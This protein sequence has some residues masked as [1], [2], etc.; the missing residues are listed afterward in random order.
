M[1]IPRPPM[2]IGN[3]GAA[4]DLIHS[5][6]PACLIGANHHL[7]PF[8]GEDFQ[9]F[10]RDLPGEN[11][12]GHSPDAA[13]GNLPLETCDTINNSWGYNA[14]DKNY[15]SVATLVHNLVRA[16][17][18]NANYLLN[19]GPLPDGT[20]DSGNGPPTGGH[21]RMDVAVWA[22][23][24]RHAQ[25][26]DWLP[27]LGHK[28][29]NRGRRLSA[30]PRPIDGR[31]RRLAHPFG[32]GLTCAESRAR[33][34]QWRGSC[35]TPRRP[36]AS[37]ES[38]QGG[39][40]SRSCV[41]GGEVRR[42]IDSEIEQSRDRELRLGSPGGPFQNGWIDGVCHALTSFDTHCPVPHLPDCFRPSDQ[43]AGCG[44]RTH[45]RSPTCMA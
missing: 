6:Q 45:W 8:E 10:E 15:K 35:I 13:V 44:I 27:A 26:S 39:Q 12:S 43:L 7:A 9:M 20:I 16:A 18:Q 2:S 29:A 33:H 4:D 19:V 30:Y 34:D 37:G 42:L 22:H 17:G 31:Y 36:P 40:T 38:R 28:Y 41:N 24:F 1:P 3:C 32:H 25:R 14:G 21:R 23:D 11:K 5:L